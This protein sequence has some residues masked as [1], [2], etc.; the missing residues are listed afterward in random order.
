MVGVDGQDMSSVTDMFSV[1]KVA[2]E[3]RSWFI[4][5]GVRLC[6]LGGVSF[7]RGVGAGARSGRGDVT[8]DCGG[9]GGNCAVR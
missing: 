2:W 6:W 4:S 8:I 9:C 7:I 5:S 3:C 1:S